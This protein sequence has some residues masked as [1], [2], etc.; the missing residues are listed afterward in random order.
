MLSRVK[1]EHRYVTPARCVKSRSTPAA[2]NSCLKALSASRSY[3]YCCDQAVITTL[4][5]LQQSLHA[6][7]WRM[8]VHLLIQD[9]TS[10]LTI[11]AAG[12]R[13]IT[14]HEGTAEDLAVEECILV[15]KQCCIQQ[16]L[17]TVLAP[18]VRSIP[19]QELQGFTDANKHQ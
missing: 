15:V 6:A 17:V 14:R 1:Q 16:Q 9:S 19:L 7:P 8:S 12:R 18:T 13:S 4:H 3:T 5:D 10:C 11:T 2:H